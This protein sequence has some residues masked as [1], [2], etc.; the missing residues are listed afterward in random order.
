HYGF[1]QRKRYWVSAQNN[2][3]DVLRWCL[4]MICLTLASRRESGGL[5]WKLVP[6][7]LQTAIATDVG[8]ARSGVILY[9]PACTVTRFGLPI[10]YSVGRATPP[11][12]VRDRYCLDRFG[13]AR[14]TG[15]SRLF[16]R[17]RGRRP[18]RRRRV[19]P[20]S[21]RST[22]RRSECMEARDHRRCARA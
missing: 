5:G 14:R 1:G 19:P 15:V 11:R 9:A 3:I 6:A 2:T 18:R 13:S 16:G 8:M 20:M 21:D 4:T 10:C 7:G 17:D 12:G 22:A